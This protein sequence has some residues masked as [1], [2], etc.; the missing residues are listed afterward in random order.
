MS[1]YEFAVLVRR[2]SLLEGRKRD[3][4]VDMASLE[5]QWAYDDWAAQT[6]DKASQYVAAYG[7]PDDRCWLRW[8]PQGWIQ[9]Q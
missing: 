4:A 5:I 9:I 6:L 2:L 3:K 8:T 1:K 7:I